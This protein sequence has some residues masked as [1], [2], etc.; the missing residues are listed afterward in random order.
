MAL[1]LLLTLSAAR[2][3][4]A[5]LRYSVA[6][7]AD[8]YYYVI[9]LDSLLHQGRFYYPTQ[10][11]LIFYVLACLRLL[12]GDTVLAVKLGSIALHTL[13]CLGIYALV[14]RLTGHR[15]LG[16]MG[17]MLAAVP[18]IHLYMMTEFIKNLGAVTLL[19]WSAWSAVRAA[20]EKERR[21]LWTTLSTALLMAALLSHKSAWAIAFS[22][23]VLTFL[24]RRSTQGQ[25]SLYRTWILFLFIAGL[26]LL[27]ALIAS[28]KF[29]ELPV[30]LGA[31]VL[32]RARWPIN[33]NSPLGKTG[34]MA[35]LISSPLTLFFIVRYRRNLPTGQLAFAMGSVALWSLL[36]TL[37]PFLNHDVRQFG[38]VGRLDHLSYL[39]AAILVPCLVRTILHLYRQALPFAFILTFGFV[40]ASIQAPPP[41]GLQ[42]AFLSRRAQML[43]ALPPQKALLADK[44]LVVARHGDEFVVT[45]SLGLAAQQ[46]F[47]LDRNRPV[48]WLLHRVKGQYLT[49]SMTVV[50][51]EGIDSCLVLVQ[52]EKLDQW[53]MM[54]DEDERVS[55]FAENPHLANYFNK[56]DSPSFPVIS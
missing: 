51:D 29:I 40:L 7:G 52:H 42:P 24:I 46:R 16:L 31:E 13:L 14:K 2:D 53:L 9:Q 6:V 34:A 39:Q 54:M 4:L 33:A 35:L 41:K 56:Q 37:N 8:G 50:M 11:P 23:L 21:P 48:Y 45:R 17:S 30:W 5:L 10:T 19:V 25:R 36:L 27:P 44:A 43:E 47:P 1:S 55:L 38:I 20:Q 3:A 32:S 28:Q 22:L 26:G 49:S 15:W 18:A 12:T